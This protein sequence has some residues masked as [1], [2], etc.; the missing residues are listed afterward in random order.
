MPSPMMVTDFFRGNRC[1]IKKETNLLPVPL[2]KEGAREFLPAWS[3]D[4]KSLAYVS[5][6]PDGGHIW[7]RPSDGT[8]AGA[9]SD[10]AA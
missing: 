7:K 9:P 6:S 8:G 4:G 3:P 1:R 2:T 5:W 10:P